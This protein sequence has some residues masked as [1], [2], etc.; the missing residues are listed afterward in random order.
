MKNTTVWSLPLLHRR[1]LSQLGRH[2]RN[3]SIL[4][5][6]WFCCMEDPSHQLM[7][8]PVEVMVVLVRVVRVAMASLILFAGARIMR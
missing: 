7:L 6:G 1:I 8:L 3:S 4:R 2:T 5:A